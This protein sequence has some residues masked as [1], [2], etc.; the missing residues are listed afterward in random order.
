[1]RV[2]LVVNNNNIIVVYLCTGVCS[3]VKGIAYTAAYTQTLMTRVCY[4]N[5]TWAQVPA[6]RVRRRRLAGGEEAR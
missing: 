2:Q 4:K 6:A 1:M 3:Q 5:N